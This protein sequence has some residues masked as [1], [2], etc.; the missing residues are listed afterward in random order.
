MQEANDR[1][2]SIAFPRAAAAGVLLLAALVLGLAAEFRGTEYDENYSVFVTGGIPRPDWPS[3]SFARESVPQP[4]VQHAD[5]ATIL[6][7]IRRTDVHPPL[8]F[9]LL[10]AWR[11]VAGDSLAMLRLPSILATLATLLVWMMVAARA[12]QSP[13]ATGLILALCYGF[14]YLGHVV[15]GYAMAQLLVALAVLAAVVAWQRG[16]GV[17]SRGAWV[18]AALAGLAGG[19]ACLTNYLAVFPLAV[20]LGWMVLAAPGWRERFRRL[21]AAGLPFLLLMLPVALVWLDQ[22]RSA[23]SQSAGQFAPFS[24]V[25]TL[26]RLAQF[27]AASLLGGLPLYFE[28]IGRSLAGLGMALLLAATGLLAAWL[29]RGLGALRWV[30]LLGAVAPPAGLVLLG[31][32]FGNAPVELRYLVLGLP[33]AAALIAA[34]ASAWQR[35]APVAASWGFGLLLAVQAAGTAG[36]IWHPAT[37]QPYRDAIAAVRPELTPGTVVLVPYGE[38]GVGQVGS[39]LRE[40]PAEQPVLV[41][42]DADAAAA[43][44]RAAG[45]NR[46]VLLGFGARDRASDRQWHL[47]DA[48]LRETPAW[49]PAGLIWQE[50][51][52]GR[53]EVFELVN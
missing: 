16:Q 50:Q 25:G 20:V 22:Q 15:R 27:N 42:R 35:R 18:P 23:V 21:L 44:A 36:M 17:P 29:W 26:A 1:R 33:F 10:G 38:D 24:L 47:A 30:W 3:E 52:G 11:A 13:V 34:V 7:V 8:Y 53:A 46:L 45:F 4:F 39:M 31:A 12:G 14:M 41:L 5:Q 48:R 49:R 32:V 40:L 37:R 2:P 51:R 9:Q 43:P 19:L 6:E 28:G